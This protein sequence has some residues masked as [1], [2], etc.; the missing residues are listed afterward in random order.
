MK[1]IAD[2]I[3]SCCFLILDGIEPS[4]EGR[5]YVLR[6]IMRRALRHAYHLGHNLNEHG[7]FFCN[8]DISIMQILMGDAYP[9]ISR[10]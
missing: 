10:I 9:G 6:R 7:L 1:A 4:N 3:R 5:G 2:H 8:L